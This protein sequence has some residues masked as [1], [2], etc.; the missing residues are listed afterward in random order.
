MEPSRDRWLALLSLALCTFLHV[1]SE[2]LPIGLLLP[3]ARALRTTPSAIG[4]LV[5]AYAFVVIATSVPLTHVTRKV[6]RRP[7]LSA[8][9]VVFVASACASAAAPTYGVL[10]VARLVSALSQALFWSVVTPTAADLFPA[11][12]RG[13]AIA[14]LMG[15]ATLANVVGVPGSTFLGEVAGWRAAFAAV[16]VLGLVATVG[17][18]L[19]LPRERPSEG[20]V[21]KAGSSPDARRY[22][23]MVAMTAVAVTGAF[24]SL[25]YV[26]PFLAEVSGV[27]A[28]AMGAVLFGRGV[29]GLVGVATAGWLADRRPALALLAPIALQ[30]LALLGLYACG[31]STPA[32]VMLVA[33][34]GFALSALATVLGSRVLALAPG[35]TDMASAV[36]SSAFNVG[37]TLG[38]LAGSALIPEA[39]VR[40]TALAGGLISLA[41]LGLHAGERL[42]RSLG[43]DRSPV[44]QSTL[45]AGPAANP[46]QATFRCRLRSAG[47]RGPSSAT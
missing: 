39:G 26:T 4:L 25:T 1:T 15:G 43:P 9:L 41:A 35:P 12:L 17:V 45:G 28:G 7:L 29:A 47:C 6:A 2:N 36:T 3:M 27:A 46:A 19:L 24:V 22:W 37:I 23:T 18:F 34:T 31:S 8:L 30:A 10:L 13:R 42:T 16:G 20:P 5:T 11:H 21:V 33:V 44:R 40:T 32:A 14:V 38:A